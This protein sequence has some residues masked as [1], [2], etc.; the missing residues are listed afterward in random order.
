MSEIALVTGGSR[1]IG[2]AI[3]RALA[4]DGFTV[5]VNFV[6]NEG[7]AKDAVEAIASDGG[8]AITVQADVSD[9]SQ[10][11]ALF[12]EVEER[13]GPVNVLVNN[14]GVRADGLAL[15]LKDDAW[16]KVI[17]TN[18]FGTFACTR[19]ALRPML[20]VRKGRIVNITSISGL[21][22]SPGQAN[23]SAA[24]AGVIGL[25]KTVAAEVAGKGIFI[26]AVAPGLIA[27]DLT[28]GLNDKQVEAIQGRVPAK[29]IGTPEDVASLVAWLCSERA[30]YITGAVYTVDGGLTA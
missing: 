17:D 7:A 26:N 25:T 13:L 4:A 14:A 1:G 3:A 2:R 9:S 6:G 22:A 28:A 21:H 24:K 23:Y 15:G 30:S 12:D 20:R 11:D 5:A 27:T 19:R 16:R 8:E 10:V 18:L 29:R